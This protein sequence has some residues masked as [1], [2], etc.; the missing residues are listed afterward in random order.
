VWHEVYGKQREVRLD[1]HPG[2]TMGAGQEA[3]LP[4]KDRDARLGAGGREEARQPVE[5]DPGEGRRGGP[6]D[7]NPECSS[8]REDGQ[9]RTQPSRPRMSRDGNRLV[10]HRHPAVEHLQVDDRRVQVGEVES[11]PDRLAHGTRL[12]RAGAAANE[13]G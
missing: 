12:A 8:L 2:E 6:G 13:A 10:G 1:R 9:E 11:E 3:V 4:A 5:E 7:L